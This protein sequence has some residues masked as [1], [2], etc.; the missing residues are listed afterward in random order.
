M[1]ALY[2]ALGG[3]LCRLDG[4]GTEGWEGNRLIAWLAK[5]FGMWTTGL[6]MGLATWTLADYVSALMVLLGWVLW[7]GPRLGEYWLAEWKYWGQMFLRSTLTFAPLIIALILHLRSE[8][9][10]IYVVFVMGLVQVLS[11]NGLRRFAQNWGWK[12]T[13]AEVLT[14]CTFAAMVLIVIGN[15]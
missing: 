3:L 6:C 9:D 7:R 5:A 15:N 4:L 1:V 8:W 13:F 10:V 11:Y 12:H 14:G 2:I